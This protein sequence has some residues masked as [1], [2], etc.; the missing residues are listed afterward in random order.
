MKLM[1]DQRVKSW[2]RSYPSHSVRSSKGCALDAFPKN[3]DL[4]VGELFGLPDDEIVEAVT[5]VVQLYVSEGKGTFAR[6]VQDSVKSLLLFDDREVRFGT[7]RHLRTGKRIRLQAIPKAFDVYWM[8]EVAR[9][10]RMDTGIFALQC[11]EECGRL[12]RSRR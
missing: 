5:R 9:L 6:N 3:Q 11:G 8:A 10:I 4:T 7:F 12:I 1:I 2:I